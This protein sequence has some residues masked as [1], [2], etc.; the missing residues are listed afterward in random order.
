MNDA[1]RFVDLFTG[2]ASVAIYVATRFEMPVLATDLQCYSV[3]LAKAVIGRCK[4][5]NVQDVWCSW[6]KRASKLVINAPGKPNPKCRTI[7]HYR[8][9]CYELD[10]AE[11]PLTT[12]YGGHYFSP[13]Q[14]VL[15]DAYRRSMPTRSDEAAAALSALIQTA[16]QC[17][18]SPGHT[19]Q[20]FQPTDSSMPYLLEAWNRD[21]PTRIKKAF[22]EVAG[23]KAICR[24]VAKQGDANVVAKKLNERDFVFID[25]PYSGVQYSRFYHV[26]ETVATGNPGVVFGSGRYPPPDLRPQSRYSLRT[27]AHVALEELF[28]HLSQAGV[29]GFLTFPNHDCSNG[30][31]GELVH[32][33][34]ST[35]F[36]VL[37]QNMAIK[38]STLGGPIGTSSNERLACREAKEM[39]LYLVPR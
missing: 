15:L 35:Y 39:L 23:Y 28:S 25:P 3:H 27:Q 6:Q 31:S 11:W 19:A 10:H 21:V 8:N 29:K 18:A 33:L 22:S 2:S 26:L 17:A 16:S 34:A 36:K 32:D 13:T 1:N 9:W 7:K 4:S 20:P 38:F 12:A 24:G 14:A 5:F 37:K 30:M